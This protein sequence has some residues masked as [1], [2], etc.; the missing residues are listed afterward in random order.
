MLDFSDQ[1]Y[2]WFPPRPNRIVRRL[3]AWHNRRTHLPRDLRIDSVKAD[4]YTPLRDHLRAGDRLVLM[5]NHPTHADAQVFLEAT[6]QARLSTQVMAAYDV[7]LRSRRDAWVMQKLGAFSVDREGSDPRAMKQA[8]SVIE[9]GRHALVIFPEGNVYLEND[10]VTPFNDGAAF[11]ALRGAKQLHPRGKRTLVVPVAIKASY[12]TDVRP[13]VAERL[14]TVAALVGVEV[15]DDDTPGAALKR[16]GIAGLHRNLKQRGLDAPETD[17]LTELIAHGA[18]TV[19]QRLELKLDLTPSPKD[20]LTDR[21]RKARRVIHQVRTDPDRLADH[22]AAAT[23]ADE[24]MLALRF[25]SYSGSYVAER[26]TIDRV[27]E[28]VEKLTEDLSRSMP[29]PLSDRAVRVRF[30]EPIDLTP[31]V[32][33]GKPSRKAVAEVT[34][35]AEGAV[36]SKVDALNAENTHPGGTL[37][38]GGIGGTDSQP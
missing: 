2:Q 30:G 25:A 28:T 14:R 27:A 19:M 35:R 4:G 32:A 36:Q 18:G 29:P 22:A 10:R 16:I 6:S 5:P 12:T 37:W 23:W 8:L 31:Y 34:A 21:I 9:R 13:L 20:T 7:F 24:A 38:D 26:P 17:D 1:P 15:A 3:L 33:D 11:L